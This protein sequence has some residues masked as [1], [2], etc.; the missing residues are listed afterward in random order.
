MG[1]SGRRGSLLDEVML[2]RCSYEDGGDEESEERELE[3]RTW[4]MVEKVWLNGVEHSEA[5]KDE[6]G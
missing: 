3:W 1:S 4:S 2:S 5:E 6:S